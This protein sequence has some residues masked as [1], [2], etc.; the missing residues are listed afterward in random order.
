MTLI[1]EARHALN[2]HDQMLDAQ[3]QCVPCKLCG[4]KAVIT[5]A[6][7]GCGYY[8]ACENASTFK[9]SEGCMLTERRLGGWAYN[10]MEWWNRLH[11]ATALETQAAEIA[12]LRGLLGEAEG[13]LKWYA[14][15][16]AGCRKVTSEGNE[17]RYALDGDGG[18][19]ARATL[20]KLRA[21]TGGGED[22]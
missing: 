8:I 12:R 11:Q 16:V 1:D 20:A 17:A 4:G 15:Q 19:L 6:G 18:K 3:A 22:E 13:A 21:E 9:S 7:S 2:H 5:D 10:V 14:E